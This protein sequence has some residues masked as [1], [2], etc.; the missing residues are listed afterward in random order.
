MLLAGGGLQYVAAFTR[1]IARTLGRRRSTVPITP[2]PNPPKPVECPWSSPGIYTTALSGQLTIL[3]ES[4]EEQRLVAGSL[5]PDGGGLRTLS[6]LPELHRL[7]PRIPGTFWK[8][9]WL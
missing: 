8:G 1:P 5:N 6:P 3:R 7:R 2:Y 4:E 9:G